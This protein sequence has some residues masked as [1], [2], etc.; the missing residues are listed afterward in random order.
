MH[1]KRCGLQAITVH[2]FLKNSISSSAPLDIEEK[3]TQ[4]LLQIKFIIVFKLFKFTYRGR[5][6]YII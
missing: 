2:A 6:F 5:Y 1:V 4:Q 3:N